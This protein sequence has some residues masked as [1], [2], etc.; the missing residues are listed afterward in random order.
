MDEGQLDMVREGVAEP[1]A[2]PE[3]QAEVGDERR[4]VRQASPQYPV[5]RRPW[6]ALRDSLRARVASAANYHSQL[7]KQLFEDQQAVRD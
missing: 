5:D 1:R 7:Q 2:E 3:V 6:E 4:V